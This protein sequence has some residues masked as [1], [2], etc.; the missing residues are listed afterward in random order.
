MTVRELIRQ[1]GGAAQV[2]KALGVSSVAVCNWYT[3]GLPRSRHVELWGLC[4]AKGVAWK[5]P[6]ADG[7]LATIPDPNSHH[8]QAA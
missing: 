2:G 4:R 1:L 5:P 3:K 8:Q 6:G 7:V